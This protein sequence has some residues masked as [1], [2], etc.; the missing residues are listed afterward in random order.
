[1]NGLIWLLFIAFGVY[2]SYVKRK[3]QQE[4][5][6][7]KGK[8][9]Q[10]AVRPAQPNVPQRQTMSAKPPA[11]DAHPFASVSRET[12]DGISFVSAES[13]SGG[14]HPH[15]IPENPYYARNWSDHC[16]ITL[17][18]AETGE[19]KPAESAPT[20]PSQPV[21][22]EPALP[23][24]PAVSANPLVQAIAVAEILGAPKGRRFRRAL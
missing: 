8:P 20:L 13:D 22:A 2:T 18:S 5:A 10:P 16:S 17:E 1:M 14:T 12:E 6:A 19:G 23:V 3:R 11:E 21:G 15:E 24:F 9:F 7:K 4:A